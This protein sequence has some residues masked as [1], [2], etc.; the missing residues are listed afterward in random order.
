[1][2]LYEPELARVVALQYPCVRAG[3]ELVSISALQAVVLPKDLHALYIG[4]GFPETF[5]QELSGNTSFLESLRQASASGLPIYAE[6]GGLMLLARNLIWKGARYPMANVYGIDVEVFDAPQGHGYGELRVDTPNPF[7]PLGA[8]LRGH[9][10]HYS[11]IVSDAETAG[12][13]CAVVRG[14]GCLPGRDLLLIQNVMA[15]YTHLHAT[16]TPEWT[17]GMVLA[18]HNFALRA[19]G[20]IMRHIAGAPIPVSGCRSSVRS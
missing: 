9:E 10:F 7:F 14:V 5:A 13:A 20:P 17:K 11:R 18:A 4:G 1:M 6:C 19:G 2:S 15:G 16:A 3:A 8:V 12:T